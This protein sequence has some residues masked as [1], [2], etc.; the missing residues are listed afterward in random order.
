MALDLDRTD[1]TDVRAWY[2]AQAETFRKTETVE[3]SFVGLTPDQQRRQNDLRLAPLRERIDVRGKRVLEYGCGHGRMAAEFPGFAEYLGIDG[4]AALVEIGNERLRA[5]GTKHARLEVGDVNDLKPPTG[6]WDIVGSLG[7]FH[8][9]HDSW[10]FARHLALQAKPFGV[11]FIDG[12]QSSP[13]WNPIRRL[14]WRFRPPTAAIPPLYREAQIAAIFR[15]AG[16]TGLEFLPR[17]IPI[18]D[19]FYVRHGWEWARRLHDGLC[20]S[21]LGKLLSVS[22]FAVGVRRP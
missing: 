2:D 11:V 1:R 14:K 20:R 18:L 5:S 8:Y 13:L 7:A 6:D 17:E 9:A 15:S 4:S 10:A 3:L 21:P 12:Y 19:H 22:F 16:V